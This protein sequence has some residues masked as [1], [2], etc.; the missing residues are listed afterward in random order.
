MKLIKVNYNLGQN[1]VD[2]FTKSSKIGLSMECFAA[3]FLRFFTEKRQNLAFGWPVEY[4]NPSISG[5]FLEFPNF[6]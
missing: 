5:I 2:K 6:L 1:I 4:S 3:D